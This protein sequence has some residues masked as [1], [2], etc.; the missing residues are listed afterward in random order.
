MVNEIFED[1]GKNRH[2]PFNRFSSKFHRTQR[3]ITRPLNH[4]FMI[5]ISNFMIFEGVR[6][7]LRF[8]NINCFL[9]ASPS[10]SCTSQKYYYKHQTVQSML[11]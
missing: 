5:K 7:F 9:K 11:N 2:L 1:F 10:S 6:G 4:L 3:F 8:L